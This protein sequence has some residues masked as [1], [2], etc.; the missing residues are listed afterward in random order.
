MAYLW[1]GVDFQ[2]VE[3]KK[4]YFKVKHLIAPYD[5]HFFNEL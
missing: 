1:L 3:T 2:N 5:D 4:N